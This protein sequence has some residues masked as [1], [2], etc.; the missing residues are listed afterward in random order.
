M[1]SWY[2][3]QADKDEHVLTGLCLSCAVRPKDVDDKSISLLS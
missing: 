3:M 1:H 2:W